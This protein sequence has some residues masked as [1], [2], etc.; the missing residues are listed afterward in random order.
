M[1]P[2]NPPETDRVERLQEVLLAFVE[3]HERGE[4]P[5]PFPL[6]AAHPD[7]AD[8]LA[9]FIAGQDRLVRLAAGLRDPGRPG[10]PAEIIRSRFDPT[11]DIFVP[12][13]IEVSSSAP[14]PE[15]GRLGDFR[16]LRQVG[17]GGMGAVYEAEQLSLQRKVA[18]KVLPFA[19]A[20][21]PR[22]LQRFQ[23][24]ARAAANIHHPNI[25]PVYAVGNER[26]V[27]YYAMQFIEGQ[28]L[29]ALI[30]QLRHS[31]RPTSPAAG[32]ATVP[33]SPAQVAADTVL[34]PAAQLSTAR[35]AHRQEFF[36]RIA[37]LGKTAAEA[38]EHA[39][40][41]GIVHRDIKPANLILDGRGELWITDF[42]LALLHS[43]AKLTSTGELVGTL[44]YMSPEQAGGQRGL[45]DQ[46]TDI[47]SLG[48]TL[49]ELLTLEPLFGESD[50]QQLLHHILNIEPRPLRDI[51]RAIP[52][53]L[54]T[55][56][57]K[58]LAKA[59]SERYA[60]AREFA[61][62]LGRFLA[63]QPVLAR[64]PTLVDRAAKWARR[65][66]PLVFTA[67]ALLVAATAGLL[68][69]T[70]LIFQAQR[71]TTAAL[72]D[73]SERAK[74]AVEQ[75]A[76]A[77]A[78]FVLAR[79][80][81]DFFVAV[82]E[83]DL[84]D[85][86]PDAVLNARHKLLEE[87]LH[88]YQQF[89]DQ[90]EDDPSIKE[91]LTNSK[92][93]ITLIRDE[94][95]ALRGYF[96]VTRLSRLLKNPAVQKAL[97]IESQEVKSK[98]E[99]LA[100]KSWS[101]WQD[102]LWMIRGLPVKQR[103]KGIKKMV[104]ANEKEL[105]AVLTSVQIERL[106]KI[107]VQERGLLAAEA[108]V[109]LQLTPEQRD[110][111]RSCIREEERKYRDQ[112]REYRDKEKD[113]Y[114]AQFAQGK[115]FKWGFGPRKGKLSKLNLEELRSALEAARKHFGEVQQQIAE[116]VLG[117]LTSDQQERWQEMA[118]DPVYAVLASSFYPSFG[119]PGIRG[120]SGPWRGG[121]G[122]GGRYGGPPPK[123][124]RH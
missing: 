82:A 51:D 116:E 45:V 25:V 98:V 22:Q 120:G 100:N 77:E 24:E 52:V 26:G 108:V 87:A 27:H 31:T 38:L 15:T 85:R 74:E 30:E 89:I 75:K 109:A 28:S 117:I 113:Y 56:L 93:Q 21:D 54:E 114:L 7:L 94:L 35:S 78:D 29:S 106:K 103:G 73:A 11:T 59:P 10:G 42:G 96:Q 50:R 40:S 81:M 119:P 36:R 118:G 123:P 20:L 60:T 8:D 62:D 122:F 6:L 37:H 39:H 83:K 95:D 2:P 72:H 23:N 58:A 71:E 110:L 88:Y 13:A 80:A 67:L 99:N 12:G 91:K 33:M 68:V 121:P 17:R 34:G 18:L 107:A 84:V 65:H 61:D 115:S 124:G 76:R 1:L 48:A 3:A 101:P 47:Y 44:R 57:L 53:E 69:S 70:M 66:R 97:G 32:S 102:P 105:E 63:D 41:L 90:H 46:R 104:T 16:I 9:A 19:A 79:Q 92:E 86:S 64:R 43:D 112:E 49:Y 5:D 14:D 4:E 55:I 111:I